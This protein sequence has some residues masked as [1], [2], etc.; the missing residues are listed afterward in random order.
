LLAVL[1]LTPLDRFAGKAQRIRRVWQPFD[2]HASVRQRD[3]H[4]PP[5]DR[6]IPR[7]RQVHVHT[8]TQHIRPDSG[9]FLL[10]TLLGVGTFRDQF[11]HGHRILPGSGNFF[12]PRR[13]SVG[14]VHRR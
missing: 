2:A 8:A 10:P 13:V 14:I 12:R 9:Q 7:H 4:M 3:R 1:Q 6:L 5:R 11:K